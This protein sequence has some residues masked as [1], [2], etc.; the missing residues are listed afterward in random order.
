M[1]RSYL[2]SVVTTKFFL[3]LASGLDAVLFHHAPYALFAHSDAACHQFFVHLGPAVFLLDLGADGPDMDQQ[4]F[5]AQSHIS[6]RLPGLV[7]IFATHLLEEPA[8]AEAQ[9]VTGKRYRPLL[10]VIGNLGVLHFDTRE[11]YA[12]AFP[13]MSR[14]ILSRAFSARSLASSICSELTGLSPAALN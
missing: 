1:G 9:Q 14:P 13:R 4:R 6:A 5:I 10:F 12:V 7:S 3:P 2:L 8:G 11:E